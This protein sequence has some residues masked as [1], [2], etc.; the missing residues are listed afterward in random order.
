MNRLSS[1]ESKAD[2]HS[3]L[4][5]SEILGHELVTACYKLLNENI[6]KIHLDYEDD[7][8][9]TQNIED[10]G[11]AQPSTK[12]FMSLMKFI[13]DKTVYIPVD[14]F[15]KRIDTNI[16]EIKDLTD[17]QDYEPVVIIPNSDFDRSYTFFT[18]YLLKKLQEKNI[19]IK[20]AFIENDI[21]DH[22][23]KLS[24]VYKAKNKKLLIILSDDYSYSGQQIQYRL[25][26]NLIKIDNVKYY[27]NIAG[28]TETALEAIITGNPYDN[29]NKDNKDYIIFPK[30]IRIDKPL[31]F[32]NIIEEIE[33]EKGKNYQDYINENNFYVIEKQNDNIIVKRQF[34]FI[35]YKYFDAFQNIIYSFLKYPDERSFTKNLCRIPAYDEKYYI[36]Y[37]EFKKVY[38]KKLIK[39]TDDLKDIIT[40][41]NEYKEIVSNL[42]SNNSK[43]PLWIK[44]CPKT[45]EKYI[46]QDTN[47]N[48][49]IT[50]FNN[51]DYSNI[52][53]NNFSCITI[54]NKR[55]FY[56]FIEYTYNGKKIM[57]GEI[58][59]KNRIG[60]HTFIENI[61]NELSGGSKR[62]KSKKISRKS[63][64]YGKKC[65]KMSNIR[66]KKTHKRT[67]SFKSF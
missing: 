11:N 37:D 5:N 10:Y 56:K 30:N 14:E 35:M 39:Y 21:V 63:K 23:K 53:P 25:Y 52:D 45:N 6:D 26:K 36:D 48:Y 18:L 43:L 57:H 38:D 41:A 61:S 54:C 58:M 64:Y 8:L 46:I 40:D 67:H 20:Y 17:N 62:R 4:S 42:D 15:K 65:D 24:K 60:F 31:T 16:D 66:R 19:K 51:C 33:K 47:K 34:E 49:W 59:D 50:L 12:K 29:S 1:L 9:N 27:I 7:K 55:A 28:L 44:Q 13:I 3:S 32:Y 22:I 2:T